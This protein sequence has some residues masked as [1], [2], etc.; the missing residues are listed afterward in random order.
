MMMTMIM[1]L[2]TMKTTGKMK[3]AETR[4]RKR[5]PESEGSTT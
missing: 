2:M 4:E 1:M 5:S 3:H